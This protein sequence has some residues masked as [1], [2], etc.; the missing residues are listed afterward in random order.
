MKYITIL[1]VSVL[2]LS[3]CNKEDRLERR[4][5]YYDHLSGTT[6]VITRFDNTLTNLSEEPNDTL[7][8]I[9]DITYRIN[10]GTSRAYE[11]RRN[12]DFSDDRYDPTL[13]LFEC[14][15]LGGDYYGYP[16]FKNIEDGE[17][18][19]ILF[20]TPGDNQVIVWMQKI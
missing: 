4:F 20:D 10:N 8:F 17:L 9:D 11:L 19:N 15:T 5:N 14:T 16:S 18:N 7:Y 12:K 1:L 6:W 13:E 2:L 3:S